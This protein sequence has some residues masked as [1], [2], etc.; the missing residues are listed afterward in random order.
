[1]PVVR[2]TMLLLA[3]AA[4]T[5]EA[6]LEF[7][8]NATGEYMQLETGTIALRDFVNLRAEFDALKA[9]IS[10]PTSANHMATSS[11]NTA[12]L[13]GSSSI[14]LNDTQREWL[15]SVLPSGFRPNA[16]L[17]SLARDSAL[18]GTILSKVGTARPTL[19][20]GKKGDKIFGG[21]TAKR[22]VEPYDSNVGTQYV[23]DTT[24]FLLSVSNLYKHEQKEGKERLAL[25]YGYRSVPT[26]GGTDLS[27]DPTFAACNFGHTYACREGE[28]SATGR[29]GLDVCG[30]EGTFVPDAIEIWGGMQ[31][32]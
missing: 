11:S 25:Q 5:A 13:I 29:C 21:F 19:V 27:L 6:T 3:A 28:A 18:E 1:M 22:I 10:Q 23:G 12:E 30:V 32:N 31:S 26:F 4:L 9:S 15:L 24:A 7:S 8:V 14:V 20:L 16:L 17:Y 2:Q